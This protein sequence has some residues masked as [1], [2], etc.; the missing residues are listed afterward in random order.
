VLLGPRARALFWI[1]AILTTGISSL[2]VGRHGFSLAR[3]FSTSTLAA[4]IVYGALVMIGWR[5]PS[6]RKI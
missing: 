3:Q 6:N 4:L 5:M 1:A 2:T